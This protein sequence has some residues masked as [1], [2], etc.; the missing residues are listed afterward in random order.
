M[1]KGITIHKIK[2]LFCF[3]AIIF[4]YF[5]KPVY[6]WMG[7]MGQVPLS[8]FGW[9]NVP[10]NAPVTEQLYNSHYRDAANQILSAME[11]YRS[12]LGA[13]SYSVA[14]GVDGELVWS[15]AVGWSNV[16]NNIKATPQTIYRIGSTSKSITGL[17]LARL[18]EDGLIDLDETLDAYLEILP[19][20]QWGKITPRMLAS[21]MSGLSHYGQQGVEKDYWGLYQASTLSKHYDD[22]FEALEV[23]DG[24]SLRNAPGEE[25]HYSSQGTILLGAVISAVTDK[26]YF[27]VVQDEVLTPNFMTSTIVSPTKSDGSNNIATSYLNR[28]KD[29]IRQV[30]EWRP[31]DLS[32]RLPGGGFASTSSDMVLM[33]IST[34]NSSYI[35]SETMKDFWT[36]QSLNNGEVNIQNYALGWRYSELEL[37][38]L[39]KVKSAHHGGVS[40]GAQSWLLVFPDLEIVISINANIRTDSFGDFGFLY[41]DVLRAIYEKKNLLK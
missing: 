5:F 41:Q 40:R 18:V 1:K 14:V 3:F 37:E 20:E 22:M 6:D 9:S 16:K 36:P 30:K 12:S 34:M 11:K 15:G 38:G 21:H 19:N 13:A 7:H 31:V 23:F 33:G 10:S 28:N 17:A 27:Q 32:H 2:L 26:S 35:D 29:G 39:G 24:T 25:F 4:I 8:P